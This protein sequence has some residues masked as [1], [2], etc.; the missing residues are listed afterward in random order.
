MK[1]DDHILISKAHVEQ[2]VGWFSDQLESDNLPK[3]EPFEWLYRWAKKHDAETGT[4]HGADFVQ[5]IFD[6]TNEE[7]AKDGEQDNTPDAETNDQTVVEE[8]EQTV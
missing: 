6:K 2:L 8:S 1:T 5:F 7:E 3:F 4:T